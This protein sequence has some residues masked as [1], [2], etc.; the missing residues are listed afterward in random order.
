LAGLDTA[1]VCQAYRRCLAGRLESWRLL[2]GYAGY[3]ERHRAWAS[4]RASIR[5]WLERNADRAGR[6]A[7]EARATLARLYEDQGRYAEGFAAVASTVASQQP[8]AMACA[9]RLLEALGRTSQAE[10][11]AVFA[12]ERAPGLGAAQA[13]AAELFWRH[14]KPGPAARLLA[15][16]AHLGTTERWRSEFGAG[17]A[18]CFGDRAAAGRSAADSLLAT[19]RIS[20]ES[21]SQL[22]AA[23]ADSGAWELAFEVES[24]VHPGPARR[25]DQLVNLYRYLQGWR[26][27]AQAMA[28]L[29]PR[30]R[31]ASEAGLAR[32]EQLAFTIQD[33]RLLW[34][35]CSD[36]TGPGAAYP[37]LLRAA[38]ALR[39]GDHG[40]ANARDLA[41]HFAAP[42]S[43]HDRTLGRFLL[44]LEDESRVVGMPR[45][46]SERCETFYFIGLKAQVEGRTRDAAAWFTR[47]L[48]THQAARPEY[49]RAYD[50]LLEWRRAGASLNRASATPPR[51]PA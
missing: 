48:G 4:A 6:D 45:T 33:D 21:V 15:A 24:R 1:A 2:A 19:G 46:P 34:S 28:W 40:G 17:F 26:G 30:L 25:T 44:G 39:R 47:C 16:R 42:D 27:E 29:G 32:V 37:W 22:A 36:S 14:G 12:A 9:V 11:L 50:Q 23:A 13:Q 8:S 20:A 49:R 38:A 35:V 10:T 7:I 18:R 43:S 51:T 3:L 41:W 31:G 5:R